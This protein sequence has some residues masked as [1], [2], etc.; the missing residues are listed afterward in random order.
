MLQ[1]KTLIFNPLQE[2]TYVIYD[3]TKECAIIDPGCAY[4]EEEF[5]LLD[6]IAHQGLTPKFLLN[7]HCHIDHVVGNAFVKKQFGVPLYI[8]KEDE[9]LLK[10]AQESA[11]RFGF[12]NFVPSEADFY[13][14]MEKEFTVGNTSFKLLHLPGHAPGHIGFYQEQEG[15]LISGDVLFRGSF[16]RYDLPGGSLPILR[17]TIVNQLFTLPENVKVYPG[18]GN[19]TTIGFEKVNNM[20]LSY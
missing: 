1:I 15:I 17:N 19:P 3:E 4:A 14:D 12:F 16:G 7:T 9:F 6:F 11:K 8:H 10:G 13:Y 2:N 5:E 18:H 20:I